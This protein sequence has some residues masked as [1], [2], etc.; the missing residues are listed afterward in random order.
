MELP[1]KYAFTATLF[2]PGIWISVTLRTP[3]AAAISIPVSPF[4]HCSVRCSV[5]NIR[6]FRLPQ[7]HHLVT[8][9]AVE[10]GHG[11]KALMIRSIFPEPGKSPYD[12]HSWKAYSHRWT[13]CH[14]VFQ[15]SWHPDVASSP[16]K[17]QHP[18]ATARHEAA[19]PFS[20]RVE[21]TALPSYHPV[22]SPSSMYMR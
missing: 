5:W 13:A 22:S 15:Q 11:S 10:P 2:L 9:D 7:L 6:D 12:L 18:S 8:A 20:S 17:A 3:P 1:F 21:S 14:S 19:V 16:P 4:R